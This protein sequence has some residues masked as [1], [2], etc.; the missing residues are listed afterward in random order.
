MMRYII[1]GL[2]IVMI[3]FI[4]K[5]FNYF[6]MQAKCTGTTMA[7]FLYP[8]WKGELCGRQVRAQWNPVFE[9]CVDDTLYTVELPIYASNEKFPKADIEVKYLPDKPKVCFI[10]GER[11]K[12]LDTRKNAEYIEK[13]E[14][15]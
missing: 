6:R 15:C 1:A 3:I 8:V 10:N 2:A 12:I 7:R 4:Y 13:M 11:G 14:N 5:V 9:Y